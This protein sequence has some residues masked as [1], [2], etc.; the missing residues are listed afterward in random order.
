MIDG[1]LIP[2]AFTQA[3]SSASLT[4]ATREYS[5]RK[6]QYSQDGHFVLVN[7]HKGSAQFLTFCGERE[8]EALSREKEGEKLVLRVGL[9]LAPSI[10][11]PSLPSI[12]PPDSF[13]MANGCCK[14]AASA[15]R[16]ARSSPEWSRAANAALVPDAT[17]T[18]RKTARRLRAC[19]NVSDRLETLL[20]AKLHLPAASK[21]PTCFD[22]KLPFFSGRPIGRTR[23]RQ[24][25]KANVARAETLLKRI[26][27][28]AQTEIG[29]APAQWELAI[30]AEGSHAVNIDFNNPDDD[31]EAESDSRSFLEELVDSKMGY[32][33]VT[34]KSIPKAGASRKRGVRQAAIAVRSAGASAQV[35]TTEDATGEDDFE[36]VEDLPESLV[37]QFKALCKQYRCGKKTNNYP[38]SLQA[39]MHCWTPVVMKTWAAALDGKAEGV[40]LLIPPR[41]P[42]FVKPL[43]KSTPASQATVK[44][45]GN[46]PGR[47]GARYLRGDEDI[48]IISCHLVPQLPV[49]GKGKREQEPE[50]PKLKAEPS[51]INSPLPL[52]FRIYDA[53]LPEEEPM[54]TMVQFGEMYGVDDETIAKLTTKRYKLPHVLSELD[55]E[56]CKELG[57]DTGELRVLHTAVH[58]WRRASWPPT[59]KLVIA[60]GSGTGT[61]NASPPTANSAR[62]PSTPDAHLSPFQPQP[63]E[64]DAAQPLAGS[65]SFQ[66]LAECAARIASGCSE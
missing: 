49:P 58:P 37:Q 30:Q 65:R 32:F 59:S 44:E 60:S 36:E 6:H 29:G 4:P 40:S 56:D 23:S 52:P 39:E 47:P 66:V 19:F 64:K 50:T 41:A 9:L 43:Q 12:A 55:E 1:S 26:S 54:M 20:L 13:K 57:L 27:I 45:R 7:G 46:P 8:R 24:E 53:T 38:F 25:H 62:A 35:T 16:K 31:D 2:L 14:A 5:D 63:E 22:T 15:K 34:L 21:T 18:G 42:P 11:P 51:A 10:P 3:C 48:E 33:N 28:K 61:L 17:P